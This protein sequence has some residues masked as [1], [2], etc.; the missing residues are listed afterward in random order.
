MSPATT[1]SRN[2][3]ARNGQRPAALFDRVPPQDLEAERSVLGS[4]LLQSEVIDE[5]L[6]VIHGEMFYAE[7]HK[8]LWR[9]LVQMHERGQ[10]VDLVTLSRV[11]SDSGELQEVGGLPYLQQ[12]LETVPH[13]AHAGHYAGI[14][15]DKWRQ[16]SL[17]DVCTESIRDTFESLDDTP[18]ILSRTE[19][20]IHRLVEGDAAGSLRS[21][22]D[23]AMRFVAA[24]DDETPPGLPTGFP[25]FDALLGG[26]LHPGAITVIA[27]RTSVGKT[28]LA[29]NIALSFAQQ[30]H[31]TMFCTMEQ[32]DTELVERFISLLSGVPAIR[33]RQRKFSEGEYARIFEA[34][35]QFRALPMHIDDGTRQTVQHI[36]ANARLAKR[37]HNLRLLV[38][39]YLQLIEPDDKRAIREQ[40]VAAASRG[41]KAIA[42]DLEIPVLVLAQLNRGVEHREQKTPR[43]SDLRESGAIEQDADVVAFID[44]RST[45]ETAPEHE[46]SLIVAKNRAGSTGTVPL[47]WDRLTMQFTEPASSMEHF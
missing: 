14:V 6:P 16:R 10:A 19:G 9:L 3:H 37:K 42:K 40:Q 31:A 30:G 43:L 38:V 35:E 33:I 23:T 29:G 12:L 32:T 13:T 1:P 21:A 25:R 47:H 27:A 11:L 44:R 8:R 41:L 36:A 15:R 20:R 5:L 28:A 39:D 46:A 24:L 2:G 22:A 18:E 45:Y 26:G 7:S 34:A 17:I 4:C